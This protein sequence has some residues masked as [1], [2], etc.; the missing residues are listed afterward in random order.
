MLRRD[1]ARMKRG[2]KLPSRAA[3][4][5]GLDGREVGEALAWAMRTLIDDLRRRNDEA[6]RL[7]AAHRSCAAVAW[8]DS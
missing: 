6:G 3:I 2:G 5:A 8:A 4:Q 1:E 7:F